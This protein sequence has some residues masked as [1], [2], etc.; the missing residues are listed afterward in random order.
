MRQ[1][2]K[3]HFPLPPFHPLPSIP[4]LSSPPNPLSKKSASNLKKKKRIMASQSSIS[5]TPK[6][7]DMLMSPN[8]G[9]GNAGG[10]VAELSRNL[11]KNSKEIQ[12]IE[13]LNECISRGK[14]L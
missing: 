9:W 1:T 2:L 8:R 10:G 3:H 6:P 12:V 11:S 7:I 14:K 13:D 4:P 5:Y